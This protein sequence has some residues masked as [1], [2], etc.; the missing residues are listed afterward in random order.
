M[1]NNCSEN[2]VKISNEALTD[3][4]NPPKL[5]SIIFLIPI[6]L[7]SKESE[8]YVITEKSFKYLKHLQTLLAKRVKIEFCI[9]GS[10]KEFSRE[11][12]LKYFSEKSYIEYDQ[13]ESNYFTSNF[14]DL[15]YTV[16]AK[17]LYGYQQCKLLNPDLILV[18][19]SNHFI[20]LEWLE[21]VID[22]DQNNIGKKQF[23]VISDVKNVFIMLG[24]NNENNIDHTKGMIWNK[25]AHSPQWGPQHAALM[26]IPREIYLKNNVD[27]NIRINYTEPRWISE[28]AKLGYNKCDFGDDWIFNIKSI[29]N[30]K[31]NH[32]GFLNWVKNGADTIQNKWNI[33]SQ[34]PSIANFVKLFNSY[35]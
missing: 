21:K 30:D 25:I 15:I 3:T 24:I 31:E 19:K 7:C 13:K 26:G 35:A 32:S 8:K 11:L 18:M 29:L 2:N 34:T 14:T 33:I 4:S 1:E 5:Y 22:H 28:L 12:T 6:Y 27:H 10:E 16:S 20:S 9:L 17:V 23:Y